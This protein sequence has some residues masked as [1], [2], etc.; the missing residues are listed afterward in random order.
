M[1]RDACRELWENIVSARERYQ[2]VE[3]LVEPVGNYIIIQRKN[4]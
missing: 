1:Q 4:K 3:S 2:R